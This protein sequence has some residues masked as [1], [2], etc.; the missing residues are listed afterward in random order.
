[1][2][3]VFN[4]R[5][6]KKEDLD[7]FNNESALNKKIGERGSR[8]SGGQI[9]RVGIARAIYKNPQILILDEATANLDK[10]SEHKIIRNLINFYPNLTMLFTTHNTYLKTLFDKNYEFENKSIKLI[11]Q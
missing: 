6:P 7:E 3:N 8:L 9:K 2:I 5:D 1:M 11:K 4:N 10:K